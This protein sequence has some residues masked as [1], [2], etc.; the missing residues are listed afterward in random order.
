MLKKWNI[1]IDMHV[2]VFHS[3]EQMRTTIELS[4]EL[5][6]RLLAMAARRGEKG[7]SSL[8][9]RA[10]ERYLEEEERR[11]ARVQ[12]AVSAIGS[13]DENEADRMRESV[14]TL[15]STWRSS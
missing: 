6:A 8:I 9:E 14:E 13:L 11:R 15:R 3:C 1:S 12:E 10:V 2:H 4:D 5:R 7:F